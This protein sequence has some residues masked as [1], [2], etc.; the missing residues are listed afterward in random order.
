VRSGEDATGSSRRNGRL[1]D[2]E[3]V[4]ETVHRSTSSWTQAVHALLAHLELV[5]FKGAPRVLG[6]DGEGREV[7]T[8]IAGGGPSHTPTTSSHVSRS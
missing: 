5:G 8:F 4:G 2:V 6:F 1:T 7:L 3:R